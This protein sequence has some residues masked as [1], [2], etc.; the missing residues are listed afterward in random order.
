[1]SEKI[2][3]VAVRFD[4]PTEYVDRT[5]P[6]ASDYKVYDIKPGTY[7]LVYT[8][9]GVGGQIE[10]EPHLAQHAHS[11]V[12]AV[13]REEY[14]T[15]LLLTR[16]TGHRRENLQQDSTVYLSAYPFVLDRTSKNFRGSWY[17][18]TLVFADEQAA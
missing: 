11:T 2:L 14:W 5:L 6:R 12:D 18:G 10:V 15:N 17:G 7:P 4:E 9:S 13:L 8:S 16:E 1:M 3:P